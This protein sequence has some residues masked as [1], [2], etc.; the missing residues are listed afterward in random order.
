MKEFASGLIFLIFGLPF[1]V[2]AL[3]VAGAIIAAMGWI[4]IPFLALAAV[5]GF[6]LLANMLQ[7][8]SQ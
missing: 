3:V 7:E 5:I 6:S 4:A 8:K 2:L 1:V